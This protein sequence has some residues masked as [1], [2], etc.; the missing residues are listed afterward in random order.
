MADTAKKGVWAMEESRGF[1]GWRVVSLLLGVLLLTT[2]G[3][4]FFDPSPEA[5]DELANLFSQRWRMA[6]IEAEALLGLW[7]LTGVFP[8]L[9]WIAAFLGFT[10]LAGAS[11]LLGIDGQPSCG[12]FGAK[13]P[14]NPWYTFGGDLAVLAALWYWRPTSPSLSMDGDSLARSLLLGL[15]RT[16]GI[17][18][19]LAIGTGV[20]FAID[21]SPLDALAFL[22]G[23]SITIDPVVLDVGSGNFGEERMVPV[24]VTN[25]TDRAILITG[26]SADCKCV[27]TVDLP[28]L[29]PARET[30]TLQIKVRFVGKAGKFRQRFKLIDENAIVTVAHV[31]GHTVNAPD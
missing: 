10:F 25:H 19:I 22:R 15:R 26:G 30:R 13:L 7:L 8:Q 11:L 14:V 1:R 6:A 20:L 31:R 12:C 23:E 9:L 29:V 28:L 18:V 17:A 21:R 4:K 16:A 24:R 5:I 27:T 3:L 2:A